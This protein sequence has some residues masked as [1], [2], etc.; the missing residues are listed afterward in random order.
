MEDDEFIYE[1]MKKNDYSGLEIAPTRILSEEPYDRLDEAEEWFKTIQLKHGLAISSMQS[2]W[3]GR[4]E[5]LFGT[6]E[7]RDT[8][9]KYTKKAIEFAETIGCENLVFGCPKNRN[10]PKGADVTC[11]YE[12]FKQIGDYA[13]EHN[14]VIGMEANPT[15]Y[16]TNY[17]NTTSEALKLVERVNSKGFLL[18]LDIGTMIQNNEEAEV[19]VGK[20]RFINHVH[21]SEPGLK[22]I[23]ARGLHQDIKMVLE[24]EHYQGYISIEMGKSDDLRQIGNV[25]KYIKGIFR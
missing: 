15:I 22:L 19:L 1:L 10:I 4:E 2:I 9:L 18:N 6:T 23:K 3:Y 11:A 20:V 24:K 5:K 12:F 17:I 8:L 21:I 16:N 13:Y 25:M 14:T 7:E